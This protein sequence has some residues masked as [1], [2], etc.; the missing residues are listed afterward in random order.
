[1]LGGKTILVDMKVVQGPL[2][3]NMIISNDC[4]HAMKVVVYMLFRVMHFPHNQIIVTIYQLASKNHHPNSTL[5]HVSIYIF[6]LFRWNLPPPWVNFVESY[7]QCLIVF[8]K[9]PLFAC[10]HYREKGLYNW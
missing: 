2:Y 10:L 4:V 9:D 6:L 7:P 5:S 3:L 1:M 8:E